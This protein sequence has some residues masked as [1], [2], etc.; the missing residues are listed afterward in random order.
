MNGTLSNRG[1]LGDLGYNWFEVVRLNL[2][3]L[4]MFGFAGHLY[5]RLILSETWHRSFS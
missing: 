1:S 4:I 5:T 2:I 3:N